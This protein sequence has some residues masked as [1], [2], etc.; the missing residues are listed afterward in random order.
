MRTVPVLVAALATSVLP[1]VPPAAAT[2]SGIHRILLTPTATPDRSQYVSWSRASASSGQRVVAVASNGLTVTTPARRKLGTTPGTAGSRQ[3][4]Y[5]ASL[6]GLAPSTRYRYRIV[7]RGVTTRWRAFTT[8]GPANRSFRLLQF[9][10]TQNDNDGIPDRII[11]RATE[12]FPDARLLLQAGDVVN[13]PWVGREWSQLHEAL[14]PAGQWRNW[15]SSIGN[16]EQ[17]R[18]KSPCRS[19]AGRGFRSYFQF[20]S[21]G[22]PDQRRTWFFVDQGPAR[23]IV[24]DTFASDLRPQRS[25]LAHALRTNRRP[26]SIVLMHS[27]PFASVGDRRNTEMRKWFLPTLERYDA[28]L[29]LSG[30][31]HSY[32]RGRKAGVTYLT[33]VSGPKYYDSSSRDWRAGGATRVKAAYRTSTYQV[34]TVTPTSLKVRAVVGHRGKDARPATKVGQTFD[35]FTLT[36]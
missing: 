2:P 1:A 20:P 14:S 10:D 24:L 7:G 3:Y 15:I 26:W 9:G 30:H 6:A 22:F 35:G 21:N 11:T 33:S 8:A 5:V 27:G 36:R 19:G 32:A 4:R 34:I 31:D 23:V 28:D 13:K 17:C 16:H 29:V 12:R 18:L 25:F